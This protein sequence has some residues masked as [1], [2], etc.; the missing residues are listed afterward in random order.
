MSVPPMPPLAPAAAAPRGFALIEALIALLIFSLA[1]LGL[2]GL[3]ASMTRATSSAKY[4]ADAAYLAAD[5]VG[6]MWSDSGNLPSYG[7]CDRYPRCQQWRARVADSLPG[8]DGSTSVDTA[9]PGRVTVT[10]RWQAPG[11]EAHV[12]ETT[13]VIGANATAAI[14]AADQDGDRHAS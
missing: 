3:Q 10:V 2:V 5:L 8:G 1:V 12:F 6:T 11:E 7:A 14:D 13:T 4:R 9:V